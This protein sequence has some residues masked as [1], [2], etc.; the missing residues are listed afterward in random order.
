MASLRYSSLLVMLAA[1]GC[2]TSGPPTTTTKASHSRSQCRVKSDRVLAHNAVGPSWISWKSPCLP[3][4]DLVYVD[5]DSWE[6]WVM[7][8]RGGNRRCITCPGA[9]ALGVDFPLDHDGRGPKIH[10]KGDPEAHPSRPIIL[11]KAEN[12][13]SK[14]RRLLNAPSIGWDNDLWALDVCTRRY[15]RLTNLARR[16]G[17]QHSAISDDGRWYVYPRR[18]ATG[19]ALR[20][21]GYA[22]MAFNTLQVDRDGGIRLV[23]RFE[24][25]PNGPMYYEPND[26]HRDAAG[27]YSLY[28]VAGSGTVMDPYRYSWHDGTGATGKNT[29][30]QT[31]ADLHEE[32]TMISPAGTKMA[33]MRGPKQW[34]A[35]HADLHIST[36][37][38]E[39]VERVTWYNDCKVWPHRCKRDGAQLSRLEWSGDGKALYFGLWIHGG[40]L[41]PFQHTELHRVDFAGRCGR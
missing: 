31:T 39:Q 14:H 37:G 1:T 9:N 8:R 24:I 32:F 16:E 36:P 27:S 35:Y 3:N 18:Y 15:T 33:W 34:L 22:K 11:F 19:K 6:L 23:K 4:A 30:L 41:S 21:F 13:N 40:R 12:D 17:L 7:D 25:E 10:W 20:S 5:T 38:F 28:Y 29:A 2:A 26:I